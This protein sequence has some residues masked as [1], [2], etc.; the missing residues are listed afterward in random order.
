M[1]HQH[2]STIAEPVLVLGGDG[3]LGRAWI[4]LIRRSGTAC[5]CPTVDE[6]DLRDHASIERVA[7]GPW[8]TVINCAAYTDVDGAESAE[9]LANQV[10]ADGVEWLADAC[11]RSGAMLVHYST[12]YVFDG[13]ASA[14]IPSD[15]P[16]CPLGAYGRSKALG[17]ERI[18]SSGARHLIVRTSWLYAPW[19]KNFVLTI[20]RLLT[21]HPELR[22]V[23]DQRGRPTSAQHLAAN[24][25]GLLLHGAEGVWHLTD[26]GECS[27]FEF[28]Q[29]IAA[30]TPGAGKV[31]PCTTGE[32][33][34]PARR[35]AYSV[36]DISKSESLLG[37][38]PRW[39]DCLGQV[40]GQLRDQ[41]TACR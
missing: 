5:H 8:K 25:L 27:W 15:A 40:V 36:L 18:E 29:A 9:D 16:R 17:E 1:T 7:I 12:D 34:R 41:F 35:P 20:R 37:P 21:E 3:M 4:E 22:V 24:T 6:I 10:N 31:V 19:G 14:P 11:R 13:T 39:R 2:L 28:A 30:L 33:P 32:F 38:I 26:A 23:N